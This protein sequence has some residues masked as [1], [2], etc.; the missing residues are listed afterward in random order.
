[1]LLICKNKNNEKKSKLTYVF[2]FFFP[3][4]LA[5]KVYIPSMKIKVLSYLASATCS[6]GL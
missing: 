5:N 1:M 6:A 2:V 4:F 3:L